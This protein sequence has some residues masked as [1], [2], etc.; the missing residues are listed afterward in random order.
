MIT[1][2][3]KND[4]YLFAYDDDAEAEESKGEGEGVSNIEEDEEGKK[5]RVYPRPHNPMINAGAIMTVGIIDPHL[6]IGDR[7]DDIFSYFERAAGNEYLSFNASI[8]LS[9]RE[10]ADRNNCLAYYMKEAGCYKPRPDRIEGKMVN[11]EK[12]MDNFKAAESKFKQ[13]LELYFQLCSLE[14]T[15]QSSSVIAAT[16]ANGGVLVEVENL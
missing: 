1:N 7:F 11:Q 4:I 15:A 8:F 13:S 2:G 12:E 14:T 3:Y 10:S 6:S 5:W 9:E 16:L